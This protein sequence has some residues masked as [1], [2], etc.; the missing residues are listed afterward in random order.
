MGQRANEPFDK[1]SLKSESAVYND[2]LVG[3]FVDNYF[4]NTFKYMHSL[5]LARWH[6]FPN[7]SILPFT[8]LM[9]DDYLVKLDNLVALISK[10]QPNEQLYMGQKI[11][12]TP[13]RLKFRKF[14]VNFF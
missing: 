9:D 13:F 1:S 10:H 14:E 7:N 5:K 12:T 6:C 3:N 8:V 4:N 2:M 11:D